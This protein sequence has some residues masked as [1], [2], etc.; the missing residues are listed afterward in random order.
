MN[1]WM[2]DGHK[3]TRFLLDWLHQTAIFDNLKPLW[4]NNN[5]Q[6]SLWKNN[7]KQLFFSYESKE[8]LFFQRDKAGVQLY[9]KAT[10]AKRW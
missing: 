8:E 9:K 5:K 4:K 2:R 7:N 1:S 6:M 3:K 10:K